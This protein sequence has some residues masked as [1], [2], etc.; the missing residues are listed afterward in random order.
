MHPYKAGIWERMNGKASKAEKKKEQ[1]EDIDEADDV[2]CRIVRGEPMCR[3][4]SLENKELEKKFDCVVIGGGPAGVAGALKGQGGASRT[5]QVDPALKALVFQLLES[6]LLESATPF[7]VV[8]SKLTQPAQPT[9][10]AYLGRRVLLVDKPK[11]APKGGGLDP[12]FGG[13]TGL[14]SVRRCRLTS[15]G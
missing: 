8:G 12:F 1:P 14:F 5:Q 7:Q 13:P 3:V 9:K 15:S 11:A 2:E 4:G 10:R 6:A